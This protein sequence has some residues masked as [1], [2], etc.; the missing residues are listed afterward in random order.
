MEDEAILMWENKFL[1]AH[2]GRSTP[3]D[4]S[5]PA[6]AILGE[7]RSK[8]LK[9]ALQELPLS[10]SNGGFYDLSDRPVIGWLKNWKARYK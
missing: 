1:H 5:V 4:E 10:M 6:R 8:K 2:S 9:L 3:P 7:L